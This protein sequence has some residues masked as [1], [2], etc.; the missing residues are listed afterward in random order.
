MPST[1]LGP[2]SF[3]AGTSTDRGLADTNI[4]VLFASYVRPSGPSEAAS[5]QCR[6]QACKGGRTRSV[7]SGAEH[8]EVQ[9][10]FLAGLTEIFDGIPLEAT[11]PFV[12]ESF[13]S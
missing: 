12:W 9:A 4:A 5:I 1:T 13:L 6:R 8:A 7:S 11:E 2:S 10:I 3:C